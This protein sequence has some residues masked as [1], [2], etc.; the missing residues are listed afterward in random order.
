MPISYN[1]KQ[2]W[3]PEEWAEVYDQ[4]AIHS[5]WYS[6]DPDKLLAM[7]Q[8]HIGTPASR[9]QYSTP[10]TEF[11]YSA[12]NYD[13]DV[14]RFCHVPLAADIAKISAAMLFGEE[15]DIKC[16]NT[17]T[18][19][20]LEEIIARTCVL[21]RIT[22]AAEIAAA[23]GGVFLKVNWDKGLSPYPLLSV[24]HPDSA[25]PEFRFGI[26]TAVTFWK[27]VVE[28]DQ[29]VWRLLERH[30][31]GQIYN[32]LFSGTPDTLGNMQPL[33]SLPETAKLLP[34]VSTG[35]DRLACVY[36][37]NLLPNRRFRARN[38]GQPDIQG[39][40]SLLDSLDEVIT[41][42]LWDVLLGQGRI[43]AP[44]EMFEKHTDGAFRFDLHR[45]AYMTLNMP[46]STLAT[47]SQML[48]VIQF[49]IRT[50]QHLDAALYYMEQIV[51]N[52]GYAPQT[53]GLNIEGR[54]ESGTA[55]NIR[56]RKS[57]LTA[58]KKASYWAPAL[59]EIL[60]TLLLIDA[61]MLGSGVSPERPQV[62][63]QDSV[64]LDISQMAG[65]LDLLNR[66]QSASIETRI[67][68]LHPDWTEEDV[69]AEVKRIEDE[70]GLAM[71][72]AFGLKTQTPP[73]E[74][75]LDEEEAE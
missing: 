51:S 3:P 20:R 14:G 73:A 42:L 29:R 17:G 1:P 49:D 65:T 52:A 56:E 11:S 64:P 35:L 10:E 13:S 36:I 54:A 19:D 43:A 38:I 12:R 60:E 33:S 47:T 57:F 31:Q 41:S 2:P 45:R 66:A 62:E 63:V 18:Q 39:C 4:F 6:S 34:V 50:Q 40:E 9:A 32:A 28:D 15:P 21:N 68:L 75:A 8:S 23:L 58:A 37:P 69:Q 46:G 61:G 22:E 70:T 59:E 44:M 53:F 72:D 5:A 67:S 16:E 7:M 27:T 71:P 26:L 30:E 74:S 24:V 48:E 55:L 25:L